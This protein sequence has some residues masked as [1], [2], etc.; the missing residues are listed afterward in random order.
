MNHRFSELVATVSAH[1][2]SLMFL[3]T[4][5]IELALVFL[6]KEPIIVEILINGLRILQ[7]YLRWFFTR[8][9]TLTVGSSCLS[10]KTIDLMYVFGAVRV[11]LCH[12][13][14]FHEIL[15]SDLG[16]Y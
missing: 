1:L 10:A 2:L 8:I 9:L 7:G 14:F 16:A 11:L 3:L 12:F 4:L 13:L 5:I 6:S 15:F